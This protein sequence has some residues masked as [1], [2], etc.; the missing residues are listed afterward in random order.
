[1]D[2]RDL[3]LLLE[4]RA[5]QASGRNRRVRRAAGLSQEWIGKQIGVAAVTVC[6]YESGRR[7]I[8]N[9]EVGIAYAKLLRQL[10]RRVQQYQ[11]AVEPTTAANSPPPRSMRGG[12]RM[13]E[14]EVP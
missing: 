8:R 3:D 5:G 9:G 2:T 12:L 1:M 4:V 13:A 7:Q 10:E 6:T 11:A 14:S